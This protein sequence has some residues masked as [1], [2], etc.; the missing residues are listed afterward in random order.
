LE[1]DEEDRH[2]VL[3]M[4]DRVLAFMI[5]ALVVSLALLP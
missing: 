4:I 3:A 1:I 2:L 5:V